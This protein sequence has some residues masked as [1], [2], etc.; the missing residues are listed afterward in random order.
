MVFDLHFELNI[1]IGTL[2]FRDSKQMKFTSNP[3][4]AY[5]HMVHASSMA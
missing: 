1:L 2:T 5:A 4:E 3:R